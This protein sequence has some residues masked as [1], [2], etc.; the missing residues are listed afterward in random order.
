MIWQKHSSAKK[1]T[2][3]GKKAKNNVLGVARS[4][5]TYTLFLPE[6]LQQNFSPR[7]AAALDWFLNYFLTNVGLFGFSITFS[8]PVQRQ[9]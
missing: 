3:F 7:E 9:F 1:I 6:I 4:F 2:Q 8:F 5:D